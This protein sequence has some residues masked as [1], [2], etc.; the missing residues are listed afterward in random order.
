MKPTS[1]SELRSLD[2]QLSEPEAEEEQKN[3]ACSIVRSRELMGKE[4]TER[5]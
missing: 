3:A 4:L 2:A 5:G 1:I